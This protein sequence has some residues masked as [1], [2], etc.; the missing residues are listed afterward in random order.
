MPA[1][2]AVP[3]SETMTPQAVSNAVAFDDRAATRSTYSTSPTH[4]GTG[5]KPAIDS[6]TFWARTSFAGFFPQTRVPLLTFS[7]LFLSKIIRSALLFTNE[8]GGAFFIDMFSRHTVTIHC[9]LICVAASLQFVSGYVAQ[10]P[11]TIVEP[12]PT[13]NSATPNGPLSTPFNA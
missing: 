2:S 10:L 9:V 5:T 6:H 8:L 11:N 7:D 13:S 3:R 4:V 12:A 1:R